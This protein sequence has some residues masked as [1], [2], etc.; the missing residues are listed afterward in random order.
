MRRV[1]DHVRAV[2]GISFDIFPGQTLGLVGE[3]GCGKTTAGRSIVRLIEPTK[4]TV[5]FD[6]QDMG[7]LSAEQLRLA[8]KRLQVIFQDPHGSMNPRWTIESILT[9]GMRIHG[10][11][12]DQ[13][14]RR[15]TAL[16]LMAEVG[17]P[18]EDL[19][20]RYPQNWGQRQRICIARALTV[21]PDL[22]FAM[23]R[24]QLWMFRFKLRYLIS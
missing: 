14:A 17:L 23:S 22:T 24:F 8:R 18:G 12:A 16:S 6:G 9:E 2:D 10:I 13:E 11:G 5:T 7:S 3:S 21:E 4:G 15:Q 20:N 19:L 1:H